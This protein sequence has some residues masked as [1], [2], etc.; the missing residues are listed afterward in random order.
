VAACFDLAGKRQ[1]ITRIDADEINYGSSPAL[2]DG[3]LA[4]FQNSLY[5]LDAKTGKGLWEQ[6]KVRQN[7]GAVL[8][9]TLAG[10]Q[11]FVTQH[12]DVV[13]PAD[14]KLL[15][16]ERD[17]VSAWAAPL[18]LGDRVY[19]PQHGVNALRVFDY[20]GVK[21][22][23]WKPKIVARL[24][25]PVEV[26][27]GK[28]GQWI[29]R[30]TPCSPLVWDGLVYQADIY[31]VF[32]VTDLK[33]GKLLYRRDMELS[34]LTHY[35]AVAVAASPALIG[36]HIFVC[37]NQGTTL[38]LE[39]GPRYKVAARNVIA[40]QLDRPWPIPAQE[41]ISYAPPLADGGRLYLRGEAYL[42][43]IEKE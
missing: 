5:G 21:G 1:W 35:N 22:D 27:R 18:I 29:D 43:C 16:Q 30:S 15:Y 34:G 33:S 11:V 28:D 40:T 9:A 38:V 17:T 36:K 24:N 37:D 25:M 10:R 14:G 32:Y 19:S 31:Q 13:R 3:V 26:S 2:A 8:A 42:Y 39:P 41:A 23:L 20:G 4:V 7:V 12:G 6:R